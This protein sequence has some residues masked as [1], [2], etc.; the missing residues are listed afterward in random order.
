VI[1]DNGSRCDEANAKTTAKN[2]SNCKVIKGHDF[3]L[4]RG[5]LV[6]DKQ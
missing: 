4:S 1:E 3:C 6:F 5:D 2:V